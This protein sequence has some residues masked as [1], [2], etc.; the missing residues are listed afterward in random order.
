MLLVLLSLLAGALSVL[1]PCVLPFLPVI[2]GGSVGTGSRRRPY[3]IALGLTVSLIA[4]TLLLKASTALINIDPMVWAIASGALVVIL[5]LT[6]LLP[7]V[8]AGLAG[9][10]NLSGRSHSLLHSASSSG[11]GE[12]VGAVLTG[13]ALGPVFSSCSPTYA[14]VIATVLPAQPATAMIYL[15]AYCV[16][17]AGTLLA[18]SLAGRKLIDRLG[19][20]ANPSGW[21][22]RVI[23]VLF[24]VVGVLVATGVDKQVQ[25]WAVDK[26]PVISSVEENLLPKQLPSGDEPARSAALGKAP[27]FEGITE[28]INSSPLTMSQLRGKPVLIDFWTY[29]CINCIRTQPYLNAWYDRYHDQGLEIVGVHAPEFAFERMPENVRRAVGDAGIR[30][31]V[32]LDNDFATWRAYGNRYWPAK[33]LVNAEG[34]VVWTHF[35]EGDYDEA[36]TQIRKLLDA[37]GPTASTTGEVLTHTPGQSPET[38]LG[39][40]RAAGFVG[41]PGLSA[42]E[43]TFRAAEE[44]KVNQWTLDGQWLVDNESITAGRDGAR[45]KYRFTGREMFLVMSGPEGAT[46]EVK[47]SAPGPDVVDGKVQISG[48][49]LYRLVRLPEASP[50]E[51][52]ELTFSEGVRANAFTFG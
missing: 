9:R 36:E 40:D 2:V 37:Q 10:L 20:A 16:G 32:A 50:G 43:S 33:Y 8:W 28:W 13:A 19:W 3:L 22:Q 5:G 14:W 47:S 23:A 27:E 44:L 1:A 51:T 31:P 34:E 18:V 49:K 29:S 42:G 38:Y 4:F 41:E 11:R 15:S 6:M 30:Y 26:L 21:F 7:G 17:M 12:T 39:T 25:A 35:G 24:I 46:V 52:V 45:L 48:S